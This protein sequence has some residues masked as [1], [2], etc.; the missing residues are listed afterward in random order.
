MPKIVFKELTLNDQAYIIKYNHR[1]TFTLGLKEKAK[2][3]RMFHSK[4]KILMLLRRMLWQHIWRLPLNQQSQE[5]EDLDLTLRVMSSYRER[6][7]SIP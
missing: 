3:I 6:K 7:A 5:P 2:D 1:D 4:Q